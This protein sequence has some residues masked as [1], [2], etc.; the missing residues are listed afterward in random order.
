[1]LSKLLEGLEGMFTPG[2]KFTSEFMEE[3]TFELNP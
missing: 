1:M 3:V 2:G